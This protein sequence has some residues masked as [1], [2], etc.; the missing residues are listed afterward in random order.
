MV[1]KGRCPAC[2]K[3]HEAR[4]LVNRRHRH[5][6]CDYNSTRWRQLRERFRALLIA[7][8]VAPVCGARLPGAPVTTD[9]TCLAEGRLLGDDAHKALTGHRLNVDHIV[10]HDGDEEKFLNVLNLGLLCDRD[11]NTKSQREGQDAPGA[12]TVQTGRGTA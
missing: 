3:D 10:P 8:G 4:R 12:A 7:A 2:E 1:V 9:S 6:A 11:H 5:G